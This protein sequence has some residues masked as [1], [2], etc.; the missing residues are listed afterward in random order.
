MPVIYSCNIR[1]LFN[2]T[3]QRY[4]S[5]FNL[6]L[7]LKIFTHYYNKKI[8]DLESFFSSIWHPHKSICFFRSCHSSFK[9]KC[10]QVRAFHGYSA[11]VVQSWILHWT[12]QP[13]DS[14]WKHSRTEQFLLIPHQKKFSQNFKMMQRGAKNKSRR[15]LPCVLSVGKALQLIDR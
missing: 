9:V 5:K 2:G 4:S 15:T 8:N 6:P 10:L 7:F 14:T 13:L 3:T 11:Q 1:Y 12:P